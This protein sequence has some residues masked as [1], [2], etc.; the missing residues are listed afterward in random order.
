MN[1]PFALFLLALTLVPLADMVYFIAFPDFP[2]PTSSH[3][4]ARAQV[5]L[6]FQVQAAVMIECWALVIAYIVYVFKT[7]HVPAEKKALWAAVLLFGNIIAM[8]VFWFLYVWRP[9]R[10]PN[11]SA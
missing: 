3:E 9:L 10:S 6:M 7:R 2:R 4:E 5:A 11:A 1:R 8:P